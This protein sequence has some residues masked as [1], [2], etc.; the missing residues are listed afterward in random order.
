MLGTIDNIFLVSILN[1][2][3]KNNGEEMMKLS[4]EMNEKSI[5]FDLALEELARLIHKI[6]IKQIIPNSTN[7]SSLSEEINKLATLFSPESLQLKYQIVINGRKNKLFE[8]LRKNS[9]GRE[10][11]VLHDGPPYAN[12]HILSLIHI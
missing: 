4:A 1:A 2:L 6:S 5:S 8:K 7:D 12:G 3:V 9:K 11:F 10:K